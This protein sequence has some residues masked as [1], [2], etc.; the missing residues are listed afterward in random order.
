MD[1]RQVAAGPSSGSSHPTE[2]DVF[3]V[4]ETTPRA[5]VITNA[6]NDSS[7]NGRRDSGKLMV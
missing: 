7:F 4:S 3:E 5:A 1:N 6:G 2:E